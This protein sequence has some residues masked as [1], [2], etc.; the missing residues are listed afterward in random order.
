MSIICYYVYSKFDNN[1]I[2]GQ[3]MN[4]VFA[5]SF[6]ILAIGCIGSVVLASQLPKKPEVK[7]SDEKPKEKPAGNTIYQFYA[8]F[9]CKTP[10][11]GDRK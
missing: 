3:I 2:K 1:L 9:G 11:K 8:S 7:K 4:N 10:K 6:L 5:K